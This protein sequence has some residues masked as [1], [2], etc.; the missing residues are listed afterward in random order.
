[1][2][3]SLDHQVCVLNESCSCVS[4]RTELF[5]PR[6]ERY[7]R[8]PGQVANT[9]DVGRSVGRWDDFVVQKSAV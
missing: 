9:G 6:E 8:T 3:E 2:R 4:I 5:V 7:R 1:M